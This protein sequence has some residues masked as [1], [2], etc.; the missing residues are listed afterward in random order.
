MCYIEPLNYKNDLGKNSPFY[1]HIITRVITYYLKDLDNFKKS[2][3]AHC[4]VSNITW[5]L[6][7]D[8]RAFIQSYNVIEL[9]GYEEVK[10]PNGI[11]VSV[12]CKP[13]E[14][15]TIIIYVPNI[16]L[17]GSEPFFYVEYLMTLHSL[18]LLHGFDNP[19]IFIMKFPEICKES[20]ME[21][22]LKI[23]IET[24]VEITE[25]NRGSK[26]VLM[27]DSIGATLILNFLSAKSK[28]FFDEDINFPND[29]ELNIDPSA[30]VLISPI[31]SFECTGDGCEDYLTHS[32][33]DDY[34]SFYCNDKTADKY[35]PLSWDSVELWDKMVPKDGMVI[36]L[37]D[38]ELQS[39]AIQ[40]MASIA[41]ETER[42]KIV[43]GTNKCHCWPLM[44]FLTEE[45]QDEKEDSCFVLAGMISRMVLFQTESYRDPTKGREPM[46]LLTID[47]DHL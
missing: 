41:F 39:D 47:D 15:D 34:A 44:S 19:A 20:S 21:Y 2:N 32:N 33:V 24:I 40:Q 36:T 12:A 37:G 6:F 46:N 28:I 8:I 27:G 10:N 14:H 38:K 16:P 45:K 17:F 30:C 29:D 4:L 13:T 7:F 25:K 5:K 23:L 11:M 43:K 26:I 42:L 9:S 35:N 3:P 1:Q 31:V 18:L 22:N